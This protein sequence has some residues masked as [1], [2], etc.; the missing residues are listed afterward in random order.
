MPPALNARLFV[1]TI[2]IAFWAQTNAHN[3]IM[4][5]VITSAH[6]VVMMKSY[7]V[8]ALEITVTT[9]LNAL[10]TNT[11]MKVSN[12]AHP[13]AVLNVKILTIVTPALS[14]TQMRELMLTKSA[15]KHAPKTAIALREMIAMNAMTTIFAHI[16]AVT[17]AQAHKTFVSIPETPPIVSNAL[18]RMTA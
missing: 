3:V 15:T 9:V 2:R 6:T 4:G 16:G 10:T 11:V 1:R 17:L 13:T 12:A 18:S 7:P 8:W 14:V 5:C